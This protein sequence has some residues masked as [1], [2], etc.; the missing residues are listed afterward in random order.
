VTLL[1]RNNNVCSSGGDPRW[2]P[3]SAAFT[4]G[5]EYT[6]G[7]KSYPG[8]SYQPTAGAFYSPVSGN[9]GNFTSKTT[10]TYN[11]GGL[12]YGVGLG[13]FI[14]NAN[15]ISQLQLTNKT[16][17]ISTPWG[18]VSWS[19]GSGVWQIGASAGPGIIFAYSKTSNSTSATSNNQP[20]P[21]YH[22]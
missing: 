7:I 18:S 14:S 12:Y 19:T 4:A 2:Y 22:P 5:A 20:C 1:A 15:N 9:F 8:V 3:V 17:T 13:G 21:T 11:A 10:Y 16:T 6:N